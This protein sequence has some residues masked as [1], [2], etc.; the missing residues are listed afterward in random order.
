MARQREVEMCVI[1]GLQIH[2][3]KDAWLVE[4]MKPGSKEEE[5]VWLPKSCCTRDDAGMW[6]VP[7]WLADEKGLI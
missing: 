7:E 2:E 5:R 6:T 1:E 3:T 4:L